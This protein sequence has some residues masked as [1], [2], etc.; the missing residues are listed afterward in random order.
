[1]S[2][3]SVSENAL[4][5]SEVIGEWPEWFVLIES[6][7]RGLQK[8]KTRWTLKMK[9]LFLFTPTSMNF[10]LLLNTKEDIWKNVG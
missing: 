9:I 7:N 4:L 2:G 3:S 6:Y 5:M 1:V 10:F 8:S